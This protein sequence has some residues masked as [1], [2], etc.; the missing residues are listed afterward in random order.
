L[1]V[2]VG[3]AG[4][5]ARFYREIMA[6]TAETVVVDGAA[7]ASVCAGLDQRLLFVETDAKIPEY[8]GHHEQIYIADFSG[9]YR[10]LMERGLI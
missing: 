9:P 10:R 4:G 6:A 5:I 1:D 7:A 8:D 2:P 3:T